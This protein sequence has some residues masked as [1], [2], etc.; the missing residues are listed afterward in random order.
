MLNEL[1]KMC[2][3]TA[4]DKGFWKHEILI[5]ANGAPALDNPSIA[6]EKIMLM[7]TECSEMI[8]ARRDG[9]V[10]HEEEEAADLLIRLLDYCGCYGF[11]MDVAVLR[12]MEKN[13]Q[14]PRLHGRTF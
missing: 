2:H 8:D 14:R 10:P 4:R 11:D 5:P 7:V 6:Q 9:D 12:K 3:S 13:R 1:A